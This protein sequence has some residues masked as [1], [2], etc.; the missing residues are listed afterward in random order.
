ML[1]KAVSMDKYASENI[2]PS[3]LNVSATPYPMML[4][5]KLKRFKQGLKPTGPRSMSIEKQKNQNNTRLVQK[6]EFLP[7][8][9]IKGTNRKFKSNN[10]VNLQS[11][12]SIIKQNKDILNQN[13]AILNEKIVRNKEEMDENVNNLLNINKYKNL[14]EFNKNILALA[15][16]YFHF[17]II[18]LEKFYCFNYQRSSNNQFKNKRMQNKFD[19]SQSKIISL[20]RSDINQK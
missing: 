6:R 15:K 20:F 3:N 4:D 16:S 18:P 9:N 8:S 7:P 17:K 13:Y 2:R 14:E 1:K 12:P 5:N 19:Y 11:P 10:S